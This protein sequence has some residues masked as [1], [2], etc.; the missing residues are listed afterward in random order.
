MKHKNTR[1]FQMKLLKIFFLKN[2]YKHTLLRSIIQNKSVKPITRSFALYNINKLPKSTHI[3]FQKNVCL[4]TGRY[5]G[6]YSQLHL[7]R[8]TIKKLCTTCAIPNIK[9]SSW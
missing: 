5:R 7:K 8:H 3:S 4:L 9:S 6:V 2:E 1:I